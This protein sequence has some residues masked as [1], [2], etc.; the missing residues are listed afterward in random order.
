MRISVVIPTLNEADHIAQT[1]IGVRQAGECEIIVVDG[2]SQDGTPA[3]ARSCAD[4]VVAAPR[5]RARQM[6]VGA[7]VAT[8]EVLLFL[9]AD[10]VLPH[11]FPGLIVQAL[12][13]PLV[14]GGRF[15]VRLDAPGWPFRMIETLMNVRS[16][17]TRISTGDQA[18]F[19]RRATF[20][21]LGGYPEVELME[22][23]ELSIK[24]KRRGKIACLRTRVLTSARRWQ[25]DGVLRTIVLMWGLRLGHFLGVPPEQLKAFYAD[26]R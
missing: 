22:D 8:G 14:Q 12:H 2:G 10:T 23:L 1:I 18:I 5:G 11:G 20:M 6:N 4:M 3:I 26:T 16:R 19:V 7:Q 24:L 17:W 21:A 25:R 13:E 9:H 15:D